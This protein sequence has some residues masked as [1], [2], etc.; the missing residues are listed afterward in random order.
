MPRLWSVR[1]RWRLAVARKVERQ[2]SI[3]LHFITRHC[4]ISLL[5][6]G[7]EDWW[8]PNNTC[9]PYV[10]SGGRRRCSRP[11][12]IHGYGHWV[13]VPIHH[14]QQ[15]QQHQHQHRRQRE[16]RDGNCRRDISITRHNGCNNDEE[17][18]RDGKLALLLQRSKCSR[19][20]HKI[21]M[22]LPQME[23]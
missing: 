18:L 7:I 19:R 21:G 14:H 13:Y 10:W 3:P 22:V 5:L 17:W 6:P 1:E 2:D 8:S 12:E 4:P 9:S 11:Q 15:Q 23:W 16:Y 20:R